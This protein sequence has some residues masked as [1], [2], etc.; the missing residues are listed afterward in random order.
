MPLRVTIAAVLGFIV[1][2]VGPHQAQTKNG[3]PRYR[4]EVLDGIPNYPILVNDSGVVVGR[5]QTAFN[6]YDVVKLWRRTSDVVWNG[7]AYDINASGQI[8]GTHGGAA[9]VWSAGIVTTLGAGGGYGLNDIG[10]A[11]G[12][13]NNDPAYWDTGGTLTLLTTLGGSDAVAWDI[14]NTGEIVGQ[15]RVPNG[16]YYAVAWRN[17]VITN[18]GTLPGDADGCVTPSGPCGSVAYRINTGGQIVGASYIPNQSQRAVIWTDGVIVDISP[19]GPPNQ[20]SLGMAIND[21]GWAVGPADS[22]GAWVFDSLDTHNLA[23]LI[24]GRNPF[25]RLITATAINHN[26]DVVGVGYVGAHEQAFLA[27]RLGK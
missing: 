1:F 21:A 27:T 15:S 5:R 18:L 7:I 10:E 23:D 12:Y 25:T 11:V 9:V 22:T 4:I 26:G 19:I 2:F 16:P 3:H 6:T 13:A 24:V 14:N 20:S 8:I 17:G